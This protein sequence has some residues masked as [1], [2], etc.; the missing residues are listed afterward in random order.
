MIDV[1]AP[2]DF[3]CSRGKKFAATKT[4]FLIFLFEKHVAKKWARFFGKKDRK[5]EATPDY[6]TF[7]K[8]CVSQF[9]MGELVVPSS[10]LGGCSVVFVRLRSAKSWRISFRIRPHDTV[11]SVGGG[12][13]WVPAA[14]PNILMGLIRGFACRRARG[15]RI[16]LVRGP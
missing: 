12:C 7:E 6:E 16:H 3:S 11:S 5:R 8:N 13:K 2:V 1:L 9:G 14:S 4:Q 10:P 15:V